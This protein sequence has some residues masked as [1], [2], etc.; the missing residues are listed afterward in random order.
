MPS[1]KTIPIKPISMLFTADPTRDRVMGG[2][3]ADMVDADGLG[4]KA[5]TRS[6]NATDG[7]DMFYLLLGRALFFCKE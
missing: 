4:G 7:L 5:V 2:A 3:G 1:P 6:A